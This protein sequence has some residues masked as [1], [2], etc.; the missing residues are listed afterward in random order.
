MVE[1]IDLNH[2][3]DPGMVTYEG[4]PGPVVCD[5]WSRESTRERYD[6]GST[7]Q[8]ARIEMVAN[9]GTYI[10]APYHRFENG[11]DI[12]G[13]ALDR[14]AGLPGIIVHAPDDQR[15]IG[16]ECF[17]NRPVA[18]KAV[19]VRTGWDRHWGTE[20]YF[21]ANPCLSATAAEWLRDAGAVLVGID[22]FNIDDT[23]TRARPV[24]TILL[25]ADIAVVEHLCQLDRV[26]DGEFR[27]HAVPPR[28]TG[29]GSFPV[30]AW[31]EI[32]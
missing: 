9:T 27:F 26:P 31:A 30:R 14:V 19:L 2:V 25:G 12:A 29:V 13:F 1:R 23:T 20:A 3:V 32:G 10:D 11:R 18:G 21:G 24:H 22:S 8:I 5:F 16:V 28:M 15:V 4:L 7:F 17:E 6:D